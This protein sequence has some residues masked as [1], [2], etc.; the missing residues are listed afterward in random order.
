MK[1]NVVLFSKIPADQQARLEQAFNLTLFERNPNT[2]TEAFIQALASADGMIGSNM[3]TRIDDEFLTQT[4]KLKAAATISVGYDNYDLSALKKHGVRLMNT[5]KVLTESTADLIFTLLM[6]TARRT[7]ELSNLI[8]DGKW[9]K[10]IT[11]EYFGT[12]IYGKTI[13]ILGMGRIGKAIAKR[14]H[15]GFDMNVIYYNR[16]AHPDVEQ[17]Y[18]AKRL[19][20]DDVLSQADFVVIILP[21]TDQTKRLIT[22]QKLALMKPSAILINGARGAIVDEQALIEALKNKTIKAAGLDVFEVEPLPTTSPLMQL[23]NV[24]LSPHVGSATVETRYAMA[25]CAVDNIIAALKDEK[26][27]ENWVNPEVG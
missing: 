14:A 6:A 21:L 27:T 1:K 9:T 23:D 7:V 16:S 4:P 12:D 24:L 15:C 18:Q 3:P 26:P 2:D 8:H 19:E 22:K 13:G 17:A 10:S 25:K 5:P 11:P 20:L